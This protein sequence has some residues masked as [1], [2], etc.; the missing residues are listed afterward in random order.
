MTRYATQTIALLGL[1]THCLLGCKADAS[2][3]QANTPWHD[4]ITA[5][6]AEGKQVTVIIALSSIVPGGI[7]GHAGI[8]VDHDYWDFG[9]ARHK[10]LQPIKSIRSQ[11][12][13]WWDDPEQQWANDRTLTEVLDDMPDKVHPIGSLVAIFQVQVTDEQAQAI[14][15]FWHDTYDRMR[16]GDDT[17]RLT[18]RQCASMV[19]WSLQ[20][21][22][23]PNSET[24]ARLPRD[25]HRQ[26]PTDLYETLRDSLT[27]TA[28]PSVGQPADL[29]LWQLDRDG[30]SPWHRPEACDRHAWPELPRIRLAVERIKHLPAD[31]LHE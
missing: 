1:L 20:V 31:L 10:H 22:L 21:G 5:H 11:A 18:A 8:A 19:G 27:H 4:R 24:T 9:P 6:E 26:S 29:T 12:G 25:L 17:Y 2:A 30:F 13:P 28:G 14:T 16:T 3:D 15:T 7:I 23:E